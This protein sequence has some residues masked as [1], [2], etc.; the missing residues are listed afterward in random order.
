MNMAYGEM[1]A[2]FLIPV[3]SVVQGQAKR[4]TDRLGLVLGLT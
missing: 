3:V 1:E 2:G 4:R